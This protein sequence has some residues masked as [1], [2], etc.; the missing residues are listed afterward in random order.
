MRLIR[1]WLRFEIDLSDWSSATT[2]L[3]AGCGVTAFNLDDA[4]RLIE[5][6]VLDGA[7][8]PPIKSV[9]KDVD[10]STLDQKHVLPNMG[11]PLNRG[12][13]FPRTN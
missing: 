10:V 7:P 1:F 9:T 6:E 8:I 4:L 11:L 5:A 12:V 3:R 13:W 2:H